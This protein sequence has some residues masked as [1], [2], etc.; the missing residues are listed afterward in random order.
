MRRSVKTASASRVAM[1]GALLSVD[2]QGKDGVRLAER[3]TLSMT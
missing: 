1:T 2:I 3:F